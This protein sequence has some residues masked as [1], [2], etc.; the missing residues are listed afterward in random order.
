MFA[1]FA[2]SEG[3]NK[4]GL[5]PVEIA[6]IF[7]N[8]MLRLGIKDYYVQ[9]GDWGGNI[10]QIMTTMYP[11]HILGMHSNFCFVNSPMAYVKLLIGSVF[12][13]LILY[14][15]DR[16]ELIYPLKEKAMTLVRELGYMHIQA[17]KPDTIGK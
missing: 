5:G 3:T 8:L 1:G 15:E 14:D 9:G 4:P 17:T 6:V 12:P 13:S 16:E 10:A 11:Q 7:K 2:F